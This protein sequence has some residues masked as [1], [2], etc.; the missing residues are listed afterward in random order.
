MS[1]S[2]N[3]ESDP[4]EDDDEDDDEDEWTGYKPK[5]FSSFFSS[6]PDPSRES[7]ASSSFSWIGDSLAIEV[8]SPVKKTHPIP[9]RPAHRPPTPALSFHQQSSPSNTGFGVITRFSSDPVP[10][11]APTARC[12]VP[13]YHLDRSQVQLNGTGPHDDLLTRTRNNIRQ[14]L[15]RVKNTPAVQQS[16]DMAKSKQKQKQQQKQQ[17]KQKQDAYGLW[18]TKVSRKNNPAPNSDT[19]A[20]QPSRKVGPVTG[21][22]CYPETDYRD[23]TK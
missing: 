9:H 6:P 16:E 5:S 21:T 19:K 17:Q 3:T 11:E 23:G 14:D 8:D 12:P 4:F 13:L 22:V 20:D 10:A 7:R 1:S 18:F 2:R 15:S